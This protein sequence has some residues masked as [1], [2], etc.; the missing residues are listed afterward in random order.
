MILELAQLKNLIEQDHSD[1]DAQI[2][3][4]DLVRLGQLGVPGPP[5]K[6]SSIA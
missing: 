1:L 4:H 3:D 5:R 2:Y 6:W